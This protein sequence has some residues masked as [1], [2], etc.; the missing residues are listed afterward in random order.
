MGEARPLGFGVARTSPAPIAPVIERRRFSRH[1]FSHVQLAPDLGANIGSRTWWRG[2]ATL[3]LL[4]GTTWFLSPGIRPVMALDNGAMPSR[5]HDEVRSQSITPIAFGSDTGRR[6]AP[7]KAVQPLGSTPERPQVELVATLGNGAG[8]AGAL[9][10]AGV[11]GGEA[12]EVTAMVAKAVTLGD[13]APGTRMEMVLGRRPAKGVA[14]PLERLAFRAKFD[15]KLE[16]IRNGG[17]LALSQIPISVD[18]TPLRIQG[19]VGDSLYRSARSA[20]ASPQMVA[21]YIR[22]VSTQLSLSNDVPGDATFDI[23]IEHRKAATGETQL[24]K[25]LYAGMTYKGRNL[26][27]LRWSFEGREDWFEAGG[28]G[29][30]RGD[31]QSP[32][33]GR[34][35]SN[36]GMRRHPILGTMRFHKGLDIAAG[37]GTPIHAS[38]S[39]TV[40]FAGRNGGYGNFVRINH[41][42]G[43]STGYAHMS[44]FAVSSGARV[45]QGQVIGYV[46]STGFSTGPHLHYELYKNGQY[47]N[48][49]SVKFIETQRLPDAELAKFNARKKSLLAIKPGTR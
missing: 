27:L 5:L 35:S 31:F 32:V 14:R 29:K 22:A 24:G 2:M 17:S 30:T 7:T 48:P 25:L 16:I 21:D 9:E 47:I 15:L 13:I 11:G 1:D 36:F 23:I 44:R 28:V 12:A 38:A 45:S 3:T 33:A 26:Q 41:S 40:S 8:L 18:E 49:T 4:L 19:R 39:G 34:M 10:R 42:G 37:Y 43:Y 6:M 46:G 20:G